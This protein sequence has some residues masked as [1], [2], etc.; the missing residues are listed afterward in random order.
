M[1]DSK[2]KITS[3]LTDQG[4]ANATPFPGEGCVVDNHGNNL[5]VLGRHIWQP[6]RC[7][8]LL[9]HGKH[10]TLDGRPDVTNINLIWQQLFPLY[11]ANNNWQLRM[12]NGQ[13]EPN[14]WWITGGAPIRE[15]H[16]SYKADDD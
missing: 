7:Q 16:P 11:G 9:L 8:H 6:L 3:H 10:L 14:S 15:F 1:L 5:M 4:K 2:V 13:F 12:T